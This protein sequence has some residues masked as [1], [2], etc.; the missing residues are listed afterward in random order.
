MIML[1]YILYI[2][3]DII[4]NEEGVYMKARKNIG[5]VQIKVSNSKVN[6]ELLMA[7]NESKKI[8]HDMET[9]KSKGYNNI[10]ELFKS[11][12]S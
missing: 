11:L 4:L 3:Y 6:N 2:N 7:L 9:G 8:I 5:N 1:L 10:D 12:D